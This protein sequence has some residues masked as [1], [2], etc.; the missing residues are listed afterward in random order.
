MNYVFDKY[1]Q[2]LTRTHIHFTVDID[3]CPNCQIMHTIVHS[4]HL[5]KSFNCYK[6]IVC[7][8]KE[9]MRVANL[10]IISLW[11]IFLIFCRVW[12]QNIFDT[13][14]PETFTFYF[15][16]KRL[17]LTNTHSLGLRHEITNTL[18]VYVHCIFF[19]KKMKTTISKNRENRAAII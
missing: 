12:A 14:L 11:S 13:T 4:R 17:L 9:I 6:M 7:G 5:S 19:W 18:Y 3:S 15:C 1:S 16:R 10:C 8:L 2:V